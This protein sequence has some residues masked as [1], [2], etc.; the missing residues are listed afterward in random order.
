M[1]HTLSVPATQRRSGIGPSRSSRRSRSE[2]ELR[3]RLAS[4]ERQPLA[5][6]TGSDGRPREVIA[7]QGIAGSVLVVDRDAISHE[8]RLLVAHL[9]A[10]EPAENAALVCRNY[11]ADVRVRR[12]RCRHVTEADALTSP[13]LEAAWER[14]GCEQPEGSEAE[15]D[16]FGSAYRLELVASGMRIPAMRWCRRRAPL[17]EQSEPVSLRSAIACLES[18]EPLCSITQQALATHAR[19]AEISTSILGSELSRVRESPIVLNR[20]LRET[21]LAALDEQRLSMSEIAI[22]C[23][24]IKRDCNGNESGETSWLARRLGL[25]ADSGQRAPTPWIHSDVLALIARQGLAIAPRE[26]EL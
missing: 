10:D 17:S 5:R 6:Y 7:R 24:R 18:Y 26:V 15:L 8:D 21:V 14:S 1:N 13:R 4:S 3:D 16:S 2:L 22:R 12:F 23:G 20:R 9:A 25:L 19:N 11:V